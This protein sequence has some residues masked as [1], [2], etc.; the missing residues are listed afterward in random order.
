MK[1]RW[2]EQK[3]LWFV[4]LPNGVRVYTHRSE[5][6]V[7]IYKASAEDAP[8]ARW[9]CGWLVNKGSVWMG[10]HYSKHNL[11]WCINLIPCV[12]VWI[13]KPGGKTP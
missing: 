4:D 5:Q 13:T 6:A 8:V 7:A 11:R 1:I 3:R 9:K 10:V 2:N 12:T